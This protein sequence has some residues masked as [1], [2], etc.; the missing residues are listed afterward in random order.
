MFPLI[1]LNLLIQ[2]EDWIIPVNDN[3]SYGRN[4][5][6]DA[7]HPSLKSRCVVLHILQDSIRINDD[8]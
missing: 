8:I 5:R 7:E 4:E 3:M 2:R 6:L 1:S